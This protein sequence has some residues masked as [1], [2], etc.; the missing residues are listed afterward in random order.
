MSNLISGT[1]TPPLYL[2]LQEYADG[3]RSRREQQMGAWTVYVYFSKGQLRVE[4]TRFTVLPSCSGSLPGLNLSWPN[5]P[6]MVLPPKGGQRQTHATYQREF[7][8]CHPTGLPL[9]N[10]RARWC[11]MS[12]HYN[13]IVDS[14]LLSVHVFFTSIAWLNRIARQI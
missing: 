7:L 9:S 5:A 8:S 3:H 14:L 2:W 4:N 1:W 6:W 10:F 12:S 13:K 11:V